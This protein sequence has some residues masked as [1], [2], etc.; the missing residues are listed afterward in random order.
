MRKILKIVVLL[1]ISYLI[2]SACSSESSE[3]VAEPAAGKELFERSVI[4]SQIGCS[5]CH[6]R[7]EGEEIVGPSL[8]G[9]GSRADSEYIRES[10]LEPDAEIADG[11]NA[12]TMPDVWEDELTEQ[13]I[14]QLIA[15]L[16][17]LK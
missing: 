13:Q 14:D 4:G 6:S 5:T 7:T 9:I 2:L 16:L 3:P 17:T 8:A 10:I 11:Y 1:L 15:Y 12:G